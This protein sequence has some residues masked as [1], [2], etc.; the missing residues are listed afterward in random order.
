MSHAPG[1]FGVSNPRS[2][3]QKAGLLDELQ[4]DSAMWLQ[5]GDGVRGF[6]G[7]RGGLRYRHT[8]PS[9]CSLS[10][11]HFSV[12]LLP[13]PSASLLSTSPRH[14]GIKCFNQSFYRLSSGNVMLTQLRR[15]TPLIFQYVGEDR[16]NI[17]S[18]VNKT[19]SLVFCSKTCR[20]PE[21]VIF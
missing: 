12:S 5:E 8:D 2:R 19:G 14:H 21:T 6:T 7:K 13:L 20:L 15:Q 16:E 17:L 4:Q 9:D 10:L 1:N 3:F 11:R 18:S